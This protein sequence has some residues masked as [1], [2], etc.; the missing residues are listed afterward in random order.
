MPIAGDTTTCRPR[1]WVRIF[2]GIFAAVWFTFTAFGVVVPV[3][4]RLVTQT[5]HGSAAIVG[6][7]FAVAAVVTLLLRPFGGQLAQGFGARSVI[8]L[9]AAVAVVAGVAYAL[10]LG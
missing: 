7:A 9:G 10:P 5:L 4:P 3:I 1:S 8:A 2:A 6:V